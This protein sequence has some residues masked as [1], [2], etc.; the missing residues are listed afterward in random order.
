MKCYSPR[1]LYEDPRT[2]TKP[3]RVNCGLCMGC[4]LNKAREWAVRCIH[5]SSMHSSNCFLTLTYNDEQL[6][7]DLS[8]DKREMQLFM[9]RLRKKFED[10]RIRFYGCG[11]Y[12]SN[13]SGR[14]GNSIHGRPHYHICV[15]GLDF[16]D[17]T[18]WRGGEIKTGLKG[19][20]YKRGKNPL[21]R[22]AQLEKLWS[23]G[24]STV[25]ELT[26]ESAGYVAR[27]V[28]KKI[29]GDREMVINGIKYKNAAEY[30]DGREP[31]FA[32]MSRRPGIGSDWINSFMSDVYPKDFFTINGKK[33][34]P[35]RFYDGRYM[36]WCSQNHED[37]LTWE[38]Y[39]ELK[40]NR[41]EGRTYET[42]TR[43]N[44]IEKYDKEITKPLIRKLERTEI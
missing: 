18:L 21:Y 36:K 5:E 6:P 42:T 37:F 14:Y 32:L 26:V 15:F 31:E 8:V 27:Y 41:K 38:D 20:Q 10:R 9:K 1:V 3:F 2:R 33:F 43:L 13:I 12:G 4:R 19:M 22:S 40:K 30:Y 24:F 11:E 44:E 23:K 25:G 16:E 34:K 28:T 29:V 7:P 39:E 35:P 17:K